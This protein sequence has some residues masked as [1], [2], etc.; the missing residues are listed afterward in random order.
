MLIFKLLSIKLDGFNMTGMH[1]HIIM[2]VEKRQD[3]MT[4][5]TVIN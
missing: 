5:K 4:I 2:M 3:I 1:R